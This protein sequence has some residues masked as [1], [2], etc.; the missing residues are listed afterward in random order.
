MMKTTAIRSRPVLVPL[1]FPIRTASGTVTASPLVL[2]DLLT[3]TGITGHAYIF[4]YTPL[5]LQPLVALL[6]N[7]ASMVIGQ[8]VAPQALEERLR[9][10]FRLLGYTGLLRMALAGIEMAAWDA[11]AK[12]QQMPLV[13][14]IGGEPRP[15]QAY[16]SHSMDGESLA[17]ERAVRS[18]K[19]GFR[20]V[21][22]KIGYASFAEE[23]AV[24]RAIRCA[25]GPQFEIM[26]DYNQALSVPEAKARGRALSEEGITWIEEP[27]LQHDYDG[28]A[29]IT[30]ALTTPVQMG[31]NWFGPE[32]M[33][34]SV[35][36]GASDLAMVD[37]MKIGGVCGWM[38]ASA[39]AEQHG[40]PLSSH[41]FQEIS[42][43]LLAASP[44]AH[45]LEHMDIAGSVLLRGVTIKDGFAVASEEPGTGIAWREDAVEQFLVA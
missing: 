16:D 20:G 29:E 1:E 35:K 2:I 13:R 5:T 40:L 44:T 23:L 28:H 36:A 4:G 6:D 33:M 25:V 9:K 43:H 7:L 30:R 32:E 11:F 8:P 10:S 27:T 18:A 19:A 24:V 34:L 31:E 21:K 38:K 37:V 26:V 12:Q 41:L 3:D 39:V 14:L 45:R 17:V 42:A 22:T 15:I